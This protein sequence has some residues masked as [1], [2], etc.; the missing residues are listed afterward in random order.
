ME[1][2]SRLNRGDPPVMPMQLPMHWVDC[3][4]WVA[5]Q[6]FTHMIHWRYLCKPQVLTGRVSPIGCHDCIPSR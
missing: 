6:T 3:S 1:R 2:S 5:L 4:V